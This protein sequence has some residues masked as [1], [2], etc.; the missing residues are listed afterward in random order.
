M[1]ITLEQAQALIAIHEFGSFSKASEKLNKR[2]SALIH[3]I[4][5][6]ESENE[7]RVLDRSGYRVSLTPQG[8]RLL[9]ECNKLITLEADI[10][11]VCQ[12]LASG[13][14]PTL[15]VII[16]GILPSDPLLNSIRKFSAQKIPTKLS[17]H[18]EFHSGVETAFHAMN[19][20]LMISV[21]TPQNTNLHYKKLPSISA[22]LVANQN[23]PLVNTS[24]KWKIE[25]LKQHD[26]LTVRG[27]HSML[28]LSTSPLDSSS[29][30]H[31]NDFHSKRQALL[32]GIGYGWM[33]GYLIEKELKAGKLKIIR[34]NGDSSHLYHPRI[35]YRGESNLGRAAKLML[36]EWNMVN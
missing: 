10:N 30:F 1:G 7:L 14:E 9:K 32:S 19:A 3:A 8:L 4:K 24:K 27:S 26:F 28:N 2:H 18:T 25:D 5:K 6:L 33:P 16:D 17:F 29:S 36:Q 21:I 20:N 35:Y 11:L 13:W 12:E 15:R 23:H 31:F 34:W 22:C